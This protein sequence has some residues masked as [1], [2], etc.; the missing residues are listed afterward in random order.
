[1]RQGTYHINREPRR[2]CVSVLCAGVLAAV[3]VAGVAL[4]QSDSGLSDALEAC[5]EI[6]ST[7][8]RVACYDRLA[9]RQ[10]ADTARPAPPA[11]APDGA[12][13]A[14]PEPPVPVPVP[15]TE[16]AA[17]AA[18]DAT[19]R[20]EVDA[21]SEIDV[22]QSQRF[23]AVVTAVNTTQLGTTT[24]VTE[25]GRV[26]RQVS[27][28]RGRYPEPPF[29]VVLERASFGSYFLEFPTGRFRVRVSLRD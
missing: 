3:L 15:V 7:R 27:Q 6:A 5:A 25:D 21:P 19:A 24:F 11:A 8:D 2:L 4:A 29:E 26:W 14:I 13:T 23:T 9:E 17:A 16:P 28:E 1:M 18:P 20:L 22:E 12:A 10:A